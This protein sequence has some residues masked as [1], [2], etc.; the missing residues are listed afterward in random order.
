MMMMMMMMANNA[1]TVTN[2]TK[3]AHRRKKWNIKW[4][5]NN[6]RNIVL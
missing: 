3:V 2:I 4:D 1:K 6:A 5:K